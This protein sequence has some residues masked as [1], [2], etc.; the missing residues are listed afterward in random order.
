MGLQTF[1]SK[2]TEGIRYVLT[3]MYSVDTDVAVGGCQGSQGSPIVGRHGMILLADQQVNLLLSMMI[4]CL[5]ESDA[6][7]CVG[8]KQTRIHARHTWIFLALYG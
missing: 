8:R 7:C 5:V 2:G 1:R 6:K 3:K 4:D